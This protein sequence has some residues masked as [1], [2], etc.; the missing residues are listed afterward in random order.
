ML[1]GAITTLRGTE[2]V[3]HAVHQWIKANKPRQNEKFLSQNELARQLHVDPM[4]AHKALTEL[5]SDGVLYRI[6]GK[7]TFIKKS[8]VYTSTTKAALV[9]SLANLSNPAVDINF[10][11][12]VKRVHESLLMEIGDNGKVSTVIIKPDDS[13][14]DAICSLEDYDVIFFIG[15]SGY[16][17]L[18]RGIFEKTSLPVVVL[19]E[20]TNSRDCLNIYTDKLGNTASAVSHLAEH[21]YRRI[22][23]I[24]TTPYPG[25]KKFNG[26]KTA[27]EQWG[28]PVD[29]KRIVTGINS[30]QE[31]ARGASILFNRGFDCDAVF[32]DTDLKAVDAIE[33]FRK[34]GI[35]VPEDLA[36][37]SYDGL[38]PYLSGPPYLTSVNIDY[39]KMINT[40]FS[41][42]KNVQFNRDK[43]IKKFIYHS[44]VKIGKTCGC[45]IRK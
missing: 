14:M 37:V 8:P 13:S 5:A 32:V 15:Y 26:Y 34:V 20:E 45:D 43:A 38:E 28:L 31:G 3:K 40:A 11:H 12:I 27:L 25:N 41:K 17:K 16:E 10:W 6:K 9:Q 30:Q 21:G 7:G 19:S 42:L 18:I 4:T 23:Y 35:R 33:Y 1:S 2:K 22:G 44:K 29:E 24:G 36:I 39:R